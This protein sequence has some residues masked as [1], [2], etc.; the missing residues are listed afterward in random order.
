MFFNKLFFTKIFQSSSSIKSY[1]VGGFLRRSGL[2]LKGRI[3]FTVSM[4]LKDRKKVPIVSKQVLP[5]L[6][7]N[8][9]EV[10]KL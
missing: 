5:L 3:Y 4:F 8:V 9:K 7:F 2:S 10:Y 6:L 1:S